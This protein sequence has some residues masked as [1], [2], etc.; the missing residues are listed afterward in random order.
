MKLILLILLVFSINITIIA[1]KRIVGTIT[2]VQTDEITSIEIGL[3]V[4]NTFKEFDSTD[5]QDG[6][7][8]IIEMPIEYEYGIYGIRF[9]KKDMLPIAMNPN[10]TEDLFFDISYK[11]VQRNNFITINNENK[12]LKELDALY[13]NYKIHFMLANKKKI[14][15]YQSKNP[16]QMQYAQNEWVK[17]CTTYNNKL[18]S[19]K[20]KY[21]ETYIAKTVLP[22][23]K[24][25]I[26]ISNPIDFSLQKEVLFY[27]K[28][29]FADW[30]IDNPTI[31]NNYYIDDKL[32]YYFT[33]YNS[34]NE[35]SLQ[36]ITDTL[37]K[38]FDKYQ[39]FKTYLLTYVI[40]HFGKRFP[41]LA[42]NL[43]DKHLS[44]CSDTPITE[45][46]N[47][48]IIGLK[49]LNIGKTAP[50]IKLPNI[51]GDTI[52]LYQTA[53][54]HEV[55][56]LL[57]WAS[58]CNHCMQEMPKIK[59]LYYLY[60]DKGVMIYAVSMDFKKNMWT[61][62]VNKMQLDWV[63]VCDFKRYNSPA[64]ADYYLFHTPSVYVLNSKGKIL[65]KDV[66]G[67]DLE[68]ILKQ[69]LSE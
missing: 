32:Y 16:K 10:I 24:Q 40:H 4:G 44:G 30:P 26:F 41:D 21:P 58:K 60:K 69:Y 17:N 43:S 13:H 25:Q 62:V 52:S 34:I 7:I 36:A 27:R 12:A 19:I 57:F 42:I 8:F 50:E 2:D 37:L 33:K 65:A 45:D 15:A 22:L 54:E 67:N 11:K 31:F 18:D 56:I 1:Q 51:S 66:F 5:L 53:L 63:N 49:D 23:L 20:I 6:N 48:M 46:I 14:Q 64:I 35:D 29:Y 39:D 68:N 3:Y 47:K 28:Q 59:E 38:K 55:T 9:N 61:D